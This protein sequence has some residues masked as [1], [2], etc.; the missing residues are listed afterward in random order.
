MNNNYLLNQKLIKLSL[1]KIECNYK[2]K[3]KQKF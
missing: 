1:N 3:I 2:K